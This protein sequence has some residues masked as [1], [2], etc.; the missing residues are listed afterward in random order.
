M[1]MCVCLCVW[2][3]GCVYVSVCVGVYICLCAWCLCVSV[4]VCA[5]GVLLISLALCAD[6]AIGNVQEKAMKIH[7]GSNSEMVS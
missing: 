6:A 3:G 4:Y 1:Y 5:L 2:V 7:N